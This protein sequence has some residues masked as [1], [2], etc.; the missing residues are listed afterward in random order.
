MVKEINPDYTYK[1][2]ENI[3]NA[4]GGLYGVDKDSIKFVKDPEKL[5]LQ[6]DHLIRAVVKEQSNKFN[7]YEDKRELYA[8]VVTTFFNLVKE[9][10]PYSGVDFPGYIKINLSSRIRYSYVQAQL[11]RI[12]KESPIKSISGNSVH[13]GDDVELFSYISNQNK[14]LTLNKKGKV[15]AYSQDGAIDESLMDLYNDL[16]DSEELDKLD[17][18]L[19]Y[20]MINGYNSII[21]LA[22]KVKQQYPE[23]KEQ[24][25]QCRVKELREKLT[26]YYKNKRS[27]YVPQGKEL[28]LSW[29]LFHEKLLA[30]KYSKKEQ[31]LAKKMFYNRFNPSVEHT[32]DIMKIKEKLDN[33]FPGGYGLNV[34]V[35]KK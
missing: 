21:Q 3:Y 10:D 9:Y 31:W 25:I 14:G 24:E 16:E 13:T 1:H 29:D 7:I 32:E 15:M 23:Y 22:G 11:R 8:Q 2:Q 30:K 6:Y 19:V 33:D 34:K 20:L 4:V 35:I 5:L 17:Y 18:Y 26:E 28:K 27:S 12:Q